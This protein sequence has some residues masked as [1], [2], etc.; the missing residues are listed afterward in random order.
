MTIAELPGVH[1]EKYNVDQIGQL[2]I[3]RGAYGRRRLAMHCVN[4]VDYVCQATRRLLQLHPIDIDGSIGRRCT[5][6]LLCVDNGIRVARIRPARPEVPDRD[7][8]TILIHEIVRAVYG[9][10]I[11][12]F[13]LLHQP[14]FQRVE[15][16]AS[17][18]VVVGINLNL[19]ELWR[20]IEAG[21]V[22]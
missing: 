19:R 5:F 21:D 16:R 22:E 14:W 2:Q 3:E 9:D 11:M 12:I 6:I 18:P 10:A 4:T 8:G 1:Y 13:H 7:E 17:V 15:A 20:A